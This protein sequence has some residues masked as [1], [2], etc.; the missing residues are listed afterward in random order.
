M[1]VR[2]QT[3][4]HV[5]MKIAIIHPKSNFF[6]INIKKIQILK[7]IKFH[8]C[9]C[10]FFRVSKI[11]T[12]TYIRARVN[13][14][15]TKLKPRHKK[16]FFTSRIF[17]NRIRP[18]APSISVKMKKQTFNKISMGGIVWL[19]GPHGSRG[20]EYHS[21]T[22]VSSVRPVSIPE[23]K[24]SA[25]QHFSSIPGSG[26]T[27]LKGTIGRGNQDDVTF[28]AFSGRGKLVFSLRG[29]CRCRQTKEGNTGRVVP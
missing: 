25:T 19:Y 27:F 20:L 9:R 17:I 15:S 12:C 22:P 8:S 10:T 3:H 24:K 7:E 26:N 29:K 11:P 1:C 21:R 14:E 4:V 13:K 18:N 28:H 2:T 5:C 23:N 6:I 16:I